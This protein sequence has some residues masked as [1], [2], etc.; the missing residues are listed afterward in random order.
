MIIGG[1]DAAADDDDCD[2]D[3]NYLKN[4]RWLLFVQL[5]ICINRCYRN[6]ENS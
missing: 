2:A 1:V 6:A 4:V 5:N 3:E